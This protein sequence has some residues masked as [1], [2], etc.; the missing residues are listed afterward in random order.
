MTHKSLNIVLG[1]AASL[2][3]AYGMPQL[4]LLN[5]AAKCF[6]LEHVEPGTTLKVEYFAPGMCRRAEFG[7]Y[8][9]RWSQIWCWK[10]T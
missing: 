7:Y 5:K 4:L 10:A 3:G 1:L 8:T 6:K 9:H 2:L